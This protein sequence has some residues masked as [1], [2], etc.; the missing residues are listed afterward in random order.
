MEKIIRNYH[1]HTSRC[2]HAERVSDEEYVLEA[3]KEGF[4]VLGFADHAPFPNIVHSIM[5][6]NFEVLPDYI[7]SINHLKEKYKDKIDIK[8]G[9]EIEYYEEKDQYY[10]DLLNKYKLD[11]LILGQHVAYKPNGKKQFY[12]DHQHDNDIEGFKKYKDAL[13][14]GI[15]SGYFAYVCHPDLF[16]SCASIFDEEIRKISEEICIAAKNKNIPLEINI[17]G[18][19]KFHNKSLEKDVIGY[20][21]VEFFKIAKQIGNKFIFGIDA[22]SP[23]KI[24]DIPYSLIE[25][26]LK[27]TDI[28]NSDIIDC[29]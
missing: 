23:S 4:K 25:E 26:F 2:G 29:F 22:H 3:I 14:K 17:N 5:R 16:L 27:D 10:F 21:S 7:Y 6:M 1:T 19:I 9:L 15:D 8:L 24:K 28:T 20:P 13:I 12:Y 18:L 11:Y